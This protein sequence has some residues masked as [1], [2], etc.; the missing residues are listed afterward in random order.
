[1]PLPRSAGVFS[2]FGTWKMLLERLFW[3]NVVKCSKSPYFGVRSPHKTMHNVKLCNC[4]STLRFERITKLKTR[5]EK[6]KTPENTWF[7][8]GFW[9]TREDSNL[10]PLESE[11]NALSS[12]ATGTYTQNIQFSGSSGLKCRSLTLYPAEL[13]AQER[14]LWTAEHIITQVSLRCKGNLEI[15]AR[16]PSL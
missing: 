5:R 14:F 15:T 2:S 3:K 4:S 9:R 13:R 10:W 16:D 12:W 6:D 8:W 1:M 11:S 7:F